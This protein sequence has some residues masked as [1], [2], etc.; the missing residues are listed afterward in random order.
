MIIA[1]VIDQSANRKAHTVHQLVLRVRRDA[2]HRVVIGYVGDLVGGSGRVDLFPK[3]LW[4]ELQH[5]KVLIVLLEKRVEL[6]KVNEPDS[7]W[8][9]G[10]VLE[11]PA[12]GKLGHFERLRVDDEILDDVVIENTARVTPITSKFSEVPAL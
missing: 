10:G 2:A 4:L 9:H 3:G 6:A 12:A 7:K 1:R 11:A 5:R 8:T